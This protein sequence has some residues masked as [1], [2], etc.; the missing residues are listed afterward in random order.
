MIPKRYL[1]MARVLVVREG[2]D[3]I[4]YEGQMVVS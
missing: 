2:D 3:L 4:F 1:L